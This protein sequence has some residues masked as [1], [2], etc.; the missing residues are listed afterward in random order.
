MKHILIFF[1]ALIIAGIGFGQSDSIINVAIEEVKISKKGERY[2]SVDRI[3]N[4][5]E[6]RSYSPVAVVSADGNK[7]YGFI[8]PKG[9]FF[10][11]PEFISYSLIQYEIIP[12][13][14]ETGW[15]FY[16]ISTGFIHDS[17][18][19]EYQ[20]LSSEIILIAKDFKWGAITQNKKEKRIIEP[21]YK[22]IQYTGSGLKALKFNEWKIFYDKDSLVKTL[23]YDSIDFFGSFLVYSIERKKGLYKL[24]NHP[25]F[26]VPF[27]GPEYDYLEKSL[28]NLLEVKRNGKMGIIDYEAREL[29]PIAYDSIQLALQEDSQYLRI[30]LYDNGNETIKEGD[31]GFEDLVPIKIKVNEYCELWGYANEKDSIVIDPRYTEV[32]KFKGDSAIVYL[33]GRCG[34]INSENEWLVEPENHELYHAGLYERDS[35]GKV[36][37]LLKG[38]KYDKIENVIPGLVKVKSNNFWGVSNLNGKLIIDVYYD[39]IISSIKDSIF[40]LY[41]GKKIG[42][43]DFKGDTLLGLTDRFDKIFQFIEGRAKIMKQGKYGFIDARGNIRVAPQYIEA[44]DYKEGAAAV[45]INGKWGF[46]DKDENILVQPLYSEVRQFKNGIAR[47]KQKNKWY[48]I[49]RKG[50]KINSSPYDQIL[51]T[52]NDNW[53]LINDKKQGL[54]DVLGREMLAPRYEYLQ[55]LNTGMVIVKKENKWGI[56]DSKEN[57]II[58]RDYDYIIYSP[59]NNLFGLMKNGVEELIELNMQK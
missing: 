13:L 30:T 14:D 55:D 16:K 35:T 45:I 19:D 26:V 23:E 32:K 41:K 2:I 53:L 47:V 39:K 8:N 1:L 38:N 42:I 51:E 28:G 48:F 46:I 12:V 49:D 40:V 33:D 29:I 10:I 15:K 17:G 20:I 54:A 3:K 34:I 27:T 5:V 57:I 4:K 44:F 18:F 24:S 22:R 58:P 59:E 9:K 21:I 50:N 31:Y 37:Y 25:F 56:V 7:K 36:N 11:N 6:G 43:T 52:E